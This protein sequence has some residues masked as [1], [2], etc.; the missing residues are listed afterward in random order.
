MS[1]RK[2]SSYSNVLLRTAAINTY[3]EL[4]SLDIL[5]LSDTHHLSKLDDVVFEKFKRQLTQDENGCFETNLIQKEGQSK[6]ENTIAG[7]L[8]RLKNLV[9]NLQQEPEKFK[10][11]DDI[12]KAQIENGIVAR[13][14]MT[15]DANKEFYLPHKPVF[16]EGQKQPSKSPLRCVC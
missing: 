12:I 2:E 3:E 15:P 9:R 16:R 5:G 4:C 11:Y 13:V 7:S 8:G 1:S 6:L 14:P 10:A